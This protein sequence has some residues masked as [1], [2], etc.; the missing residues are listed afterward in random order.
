MAMRRHRSPPS[1]PPRALARACAC[2]RA[3]TRPELGRSG[4]GGG[5]AQCNA[6]T[7]AAWCPRHHTHAAALG[8]LACAAFRPTVFAHGRRRDERDTTAATRGVMAG[9]RC[10]TGGARARA[11]PVPRGSL[12]PP[13]GCF[14][15]ASRGRAANAP[16]RAP[17]SAPHRAL[18]PFP[19]TR[20]A[21]KT[22]AGRAARR[23]A[24][25]P[26]PRRAGRRPAAA[27]LV[28]VL[29]GRGVKKT[30]R[31]RHSGL[32]AFEIPPTAK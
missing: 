8:C 21:F 3:T 17:S 2:A 10:Q 14:G 19:S 11:A 22:A 15:V 18:S 29:S 31:R 7:A 25:P 32:F 6:T 30:R 26:P 20:M 4:G 9:G 1:P 27:P 12:F 5:A 28:V 13:E 16:W 24:P 23:R